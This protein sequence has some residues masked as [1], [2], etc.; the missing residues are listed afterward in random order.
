MR[1]LAPPK[2]KV[3]EDIPGVPTAAWARV[4]RGVPAPDPFQ[5]GDGFMLMVDGARFLPGKLTHHSH[6]CQNQRRGWAHEAHLA[7]F[8][9]P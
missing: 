8:P 9:G 5:P 2:P 3:I 6:S 4:N 1:P 7:P